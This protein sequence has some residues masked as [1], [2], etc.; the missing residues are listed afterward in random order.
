MGVDTHPPLPIATPQERPQETTK[1]LDQREH[2]FPWLYPSCLTPPRSPLKGDIPNKYPLYKVQMGL[3]LKGSP[4]PRVPPFSANNSPGSLAKTHSPD[5]FKTRR[6]G[7]IS[8]RRGVKRLVRDGQTWWYFG[9]VKNSILMCHDCMYHV[10]WYVY[11]TI[12][13]TIYCIYIYIHVSASL[14][15][16]IERAVGRTL[17]KQMTLLPGT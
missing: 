10:I 12:I 9:M 3:I 6:N 16:F 2:R 1:Q 13:Y 14:Q 15:P 7:K 8:K 11:I 4:I 5:R 17:C